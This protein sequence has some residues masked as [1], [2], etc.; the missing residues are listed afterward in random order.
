MVPVKY[1]IC[2]DVKVPDFMTTFCSQDSYETQEHL[3]LCE[4]TERRGLLK[5][6]S[7]GWNLKYCDIKQYGTPGENFK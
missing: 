1:Q 5:L 2:H 6:T 4:G 3:Q 7:V